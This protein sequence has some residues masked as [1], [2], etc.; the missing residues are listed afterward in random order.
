[1]V[2]SALKKCCDP[3]SKQS[4]QDGSDEG[5]QHMV[6]MRNKQNYHKIFPFIS[7]LIL[8]L[9]FP[10]TYFFFFKLL[11]SKSL[12]EEYVLQIPLS[13]KVSGDGDL[14]IKLELLLCFSIIFSFFFD[15][16]LLILINEFIICKGKEKIS[17]MNESSCNESNLL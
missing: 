7:Y 1:M 2:N 14:E 9:I 6:L 11:S 10:Y 8:S 15:A 12:F 5:P 16:L 17:T 3:S 4:R 13:F